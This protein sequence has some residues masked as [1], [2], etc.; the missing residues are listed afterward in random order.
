MHTTIKQFIGALRKGQRLPFDEVETIFRREWTSA[1]FEDTYQ[2]ECYL[3][4]GIMQLRAFHAKCLAES[5]E[6]WAQERAFTLDLANGVQITGRM[7]QIN[8]AIP[9]S[10][11]EPE[12]AAGIPVEIVDYKTGR[13]RTQ[14]AADKDL[15]L[16][17][18]ALAARE[19]LGLVPERLVY[20]NLQTNECV[21]GER[22]EEQLNKV[23]GTIQEVAADIRARAFPARPGFRCRT[24][25]YRFLCP[26]QESRHGPL[27]E[28]EADARPGD[29]ATTPAQA[30]PSI[31]GE[32]KW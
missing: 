14:A 27:G 10:G 19:A 7:D 24:C 4:D 28:F 20:Y 16:G 15:Q 30:R 1:G 5:P 26:A 31:A 32:E 2:E 23:R 22:E 6:V 12:G 11:P 18:Y 3:G 29:V 9:G 13:P 21:A 17:I 25:E 8:R